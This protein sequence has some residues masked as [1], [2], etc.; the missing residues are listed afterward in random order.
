MNVD[1][2]RR[3]TDTIWEIPKQGAMRVPGRV[4]ANRALLESILKDKA[5]EQVANVACLPG[6]VGYAL[7]MP[8]AHWGY[9]F[10]IGGVAATD[11]DQGGVISP[12][13]V[14]YDINCGCRLIATRLRIGEVRDALPRIVNGLYR[15]IPCGVGSSGA[16]EKLAKPDLERV[17]ETGARWAVEHGF[18][19]AADLDTTEENGCMPGADPSVLS[20]RAVS[21]GENQLGTLGSGNHFAEL[22]VVEQVFDPHVARVFAL[23]E[24]SVTLMIHSGSRGLGYQVCDDFLEVMVRASAQYRIELPDRQ[25]CCAPVHSEQGRRYLAAM[26]AA[27]NY[28]W[29]NRQIIMEL[30]RRSM[31][32]A[33]KISREELG[34]RLVYDV[35]HNIAKLEVHEVDGVRRRVCVHRKGATRAFP[36]TRD[37]VPPA[38]RAVGQPV[39][40]PGDMGTGSYVCVGT[41]KALTETFGSACHGAGR[42]LSRT[43][44]RKAKSAQE[45]VRE[46]KASDIVLMARNKKTIAE[47]QPQAYKD[48][49]VVADVLEQSGI[50]RRVVRIRPVGVIKG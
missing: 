48:I 50:G 24:G 23:E 41:E 35:C 46:L 44:A 16:I 9:G 37:E 22:G 19:S 43:A 5:A 31:M 32:H 39:L 45:V 10:P 28:A 2:L 21:R 13:G 33:L 18:G 30:A 20:D 11:P 12:G 14:G 15:D 1:E 6:I 40:L 25:L 34:A 7:A 26:A 27:A 36:G 3:V 49:D 4:I 38:Y 29:A 42:V 17:L 47:E 8:D